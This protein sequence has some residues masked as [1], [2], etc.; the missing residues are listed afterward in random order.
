[1]VQVSKLKK[2]QIKK[3]TLSTC[4][5]NLTDGK[6]SRITKNNDNVIN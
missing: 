5:L 1:M 3:K 6:D 2:N 4:I